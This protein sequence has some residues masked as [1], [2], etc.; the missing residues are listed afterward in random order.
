MKDASHS[1]QQTHS[2]DTNDKLSKQNQGA[3]TFALNALTLSQNGNVRNQEDTWRTIENGTNGTAVYRLLVQD[4]SHNGRPVSP[5]NNVPLFAS[6]S[7]L[8]VVCKSPRGTWVELEL[9]QEESNCPLRVRLSDDRLIHFSH[10]SAW[11]ICMLPQTYGDPDLPNMNYGGLP[12]NGAE[13]EVVDLGTDT[14][15]PGEVYT[16]KALGGFVVIDLETGSISWKILAIA[17]D[18]SMAGMLHDASD[19]HWKLPGE[20]EQVREWLRIRHCTHAGENRN[21]TF[22]PLRAIGVVGNWCTACLSHSETRLVDRC[23]TIVL[24]S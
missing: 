24:K 23:S 21:R 14:R 18:D 5:W 13:V 4:S 2:L 9:A 1:L 7:N 12:Y 3:A 20:L 19:I 11:N 17:L 8:Q 10:N 16:V 15:R 22:R 6:N